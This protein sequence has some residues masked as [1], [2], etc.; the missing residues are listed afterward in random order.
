MSYV[1]NLGPVPYADGTVDLSNGLSHAIALNDS[2]FVWTYGQANPNMNFLALGRC[3]GGFGTGTPVIIDQI[4]VNTEPNRD[5]ILV[6]MTE[7]RFGLL[8]KDNINNVVFHIYEVESNQ[9]VIKASHQ[10]VNYS[11]TFNVTYGSST[12]TYS[13]NNVRVMRYSDDIVFVFY[14]YSNT[15][16]IV[17][18]FYDSTT[19][20]INSANSRLIPGFQP[21]DASDVVVKLFK[22]TNYEWLV[23]GA[24]DRI[25]SPT[26]GALGLKWKPILIQYNGGTDFTFT[27]NWTLRGPSRTSS[28]GEIDN[29]NFYAD[30]L[31]LDDE[32]AIAFYNRMFVYSVWSGFNEDPQKMSVSDMPAKAFSAVN[33]DQSY[34]RNYKVGSLKLDAN[35]IMIC[36]HFGLKNNT[37]ASNNYYR[38]FKILRYHKDE[39]FLEASPASDSILGFTVDMQN[40]RMFW[41]DRTPTPI[42]PDTLVLFGWD[43]STNQLG[44]VVFKA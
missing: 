11:S 19:E 43:N 42:N 28:N 7:S 36:N 35:H 4:A 27:D 31:L 12:N 24:T 26:S 10:I 3:E 23:V 9:I 30:F 41:Q 1:Y 16:A 20:T 6:K 15:V 14:K 40:I 37:G 2:T 34:Y 21:T 33:L 8:Y 32:T 29:Y 17:P 38:H 13:G 18:L 22:T 25:D 5:K 39:D 44:M